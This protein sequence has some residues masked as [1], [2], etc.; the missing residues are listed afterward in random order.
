MNWLKRVL[1]PPLIV[2][3]ALLMWC[4]EW[5]WERLKLL[6][7]WI[8]QFPPVRAYE[9]FIRSLPPYPTM[10]VF[11]LPEAFLIPIKLLTLYWLTQGHWVLSM[12]VY[13]LAKVLGTAFVVR[14]YVVC[15]PKLMTIG[16]F[17]RL[18]EWLLATRDFLYAALRAM[19]LYQAVRSRLVALKAAVARVFRGVRGRR[20][21]WSRWLA[22]RRLH[23]QQRS[24]RRSQT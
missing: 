1:T 15:Q 19:P 23:R 17:R 8:A 4:E 6:T 9:A 3:A 14:S 10:F 7:R 18:H 11:L 24:R 2:F 21:L 20:G 12:T 5:L 13:A 22:I 16:W